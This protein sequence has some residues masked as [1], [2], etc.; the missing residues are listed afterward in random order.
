MK[1]RVDA[2]VA[3]EKERQV[4]SLKTSSMPAPSAPSEEPDFQ[5]CSSPQSVGASSFQDAASPSA[6]ETSQDMEKMTNDLVDNDDDSD[7]YEKNLLAD[8]K[9]RLLGRGEKGSVSASRSPDQ[10]L[11]PLD[12][13]FEK[14]WSDTDKVSAKWTAAVHKPAPATA[15]PTPMPVPMP[16]GSPSE[17]KKEGG[18]KK[19]S[20]KGSE[21][22][23]EGS[24][25]KKKPKNKKNK[26][27][28]QGAQDI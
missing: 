15:T 25:E 12:L 9:K 14:R 1:A 20:A 7:D 16:K 6:M 2:R 11:D 27:K 5:D 4:A 17:A 8:A 3:A 24:S 21:A 28:K 10:G 13:S 22:N 19:N 18:G 26:K 23:V